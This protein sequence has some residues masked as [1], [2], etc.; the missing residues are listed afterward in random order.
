MEAEKN[1]NA[2]P[3]VGSP[4]SASIV[5]EARLYPEVR[6]VCPPYLRELANQNTDPSIRLSSDLCISYVSRLVSL[7]GPPMHG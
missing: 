7:A 1:S 5:E 6:S 3:P 2:R 4:E